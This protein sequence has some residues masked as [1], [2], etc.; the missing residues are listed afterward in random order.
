MQHTDIGTRPGSGASGGLGAG[1]L[2]LGGQLRARE[3]AIDEYFGVS[4]LFSSSSSTSAAPGGQKWD[5]VVTAE[6]CL[7][8][9]S[10]QG[11]L[12]VEIA[13]RARRHGAAVIAL[14]GTIGP[15]AE[16]VYDDGIAAFAS[17][18]DGPRSLKDA[19]ASTAVLLTDAAERAIRMIQ[20]GMR[21]KTGGESEDARVVEEGNSVRQISAGQVYEP[22]RGMKLARSCTN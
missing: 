22:V 19:I 15:G 14:A 5:L 17:I 13:R 11:K 8:A 16:G 12:T 10:A 21:L 3:D 1:I 6:G 2:I 7:D 9:Q 18:L 20:M 4:Q